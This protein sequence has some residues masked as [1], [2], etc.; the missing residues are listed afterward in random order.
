MGF[1]KKIYEINSHLHNREIWFGAAAV[2]TGTHK[3]DIDTMAFYQSTAGNNQY[4]S[5]LQLLGSDDTPVQAGFVEF[6]GHRMLVTVGASATNTLHKVQLAKGAS[7]SQQL[8]TEVEFILTSGTAAIPVDIIFPH[9]DAGENLWVRHWANGKNGT[10]MD[11]KLGIHEYPAFADQSRA[12]LSTVPFAKILNDERYVI[13]VALSLD[14]VV[15]NASAASVDILLVEENTQKITKKRV[16][17]ARYL[18]DGSFLFPVKKYFNEIVNGYTY[19]YYISSGG[20]GGTQIDTTLGR[21]EVVDPISNTD[22]S[23]QMETFKRQSQQQV[24]TLQKA[25]ARAVEPI[26][27]L[28]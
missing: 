1:I 18:V 3:G 12:L 24:D 25:G 13:G 28:T 17:L 11:L 21:F 26:R 6:D 7:G 2:P 19:S 5:W 9:V 23:R 10:T 8:L 22:L 15:L 14:K 4:G 16:T 27:I 20:S